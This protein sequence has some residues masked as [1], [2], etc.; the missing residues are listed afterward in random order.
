MLAR[1]WS[2][3]SEVGWVGSRWVWAEALEL[4][5]FFWG[6]HMRLLSCFTTPLSIRSCGIDVVGLYLKLHLH[7]PISPPTP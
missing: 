2:G 4:L 3:M 6:I 1:I 7:T 5:S